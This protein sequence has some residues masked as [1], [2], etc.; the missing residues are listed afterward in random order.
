MFRENFLAVSAEPAYEEVTTPSGAVR[1]YAMTLG[2]KDVFD[3]AH[4][5]AEGKDFR[6]R[7]I[8]AT[9]RDE[10]GNPVFRAHD[11]PAITRYP[12]PAVEPL[13]NAAVRVNR[14]SDDVA[15]TLAKN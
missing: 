15:E 8:V 10:A 7:L 3:I 6:A 11:I 14:M 9:V 1:V 13:V 4:A 12:L 5:R 2:E